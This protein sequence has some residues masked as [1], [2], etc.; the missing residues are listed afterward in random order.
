MLCMCVHC[1]KL[2]VSMWDCVV[3]LGSMSLSTGVQTLTSAGVTTTS[4][5]NAAS[6]HLAP[7]IVDASRD[8][9]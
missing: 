3:V 8:T 4:A 5:Y 6:T 1:D 7:T 2:L 9:S